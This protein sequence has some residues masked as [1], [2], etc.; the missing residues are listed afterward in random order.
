MCAILCVCVLSI[1]MFVFRKMKQGFKMH[2]TFRMWLTSGNWGIEQ[3]CWSNAPFHAFL[4]QANDYPTYCSRPSSHLVPKGQPKDRWKS[5]SGV[6][7]SPLELA[8]RLTG[9]LFGGVWIS[10]CRNDPLGSERS[11]PSVI[12]R[13]N[14]SKCY[15][16]LHVSTLGNLWQNILTW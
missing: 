4:L 1:Y 6:V 8:D 15:I 16:D 12:I 9:T 5:G 13:T 10:A 7:I 11:S 2:F 3:F 14:I